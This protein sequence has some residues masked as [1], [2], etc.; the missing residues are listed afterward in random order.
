M[1]LII[2]LLLFTVLSPSL[3]HDVRNQQPHPSF[4]AAVNNCC[5]SQGFESGI[6]VQP[7][8]SWS[9][10]KVVNSRSYLLAC[11]NHILVLV[12]GRL[13][14]LLFANRATHIPLFLPN[15]TNVRCLRMQ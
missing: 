1:T 6:F 14:L 15:E 8:F 11:R 10:E 3:G 13:L 5:L 12:L 4:A 7:V 9:Q 2:A